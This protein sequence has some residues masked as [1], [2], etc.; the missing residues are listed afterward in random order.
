MNNF[1]EV[2]EVFKSIKYT[3]KSNLNNYLGTND[4]IRSLFLWLKNEFRL[5]KNKSFKSCL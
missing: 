5:N 3:Q 2:D 1:E 4:K